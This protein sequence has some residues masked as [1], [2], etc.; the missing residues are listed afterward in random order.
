MTAKSP[1]SGEGTMRRFGTGVSG[2]AGALCMAGLLAA[3][4]SGSSSPQASTVTPKGDTV[5][6]VA[7]GV[8]PKSGYLVYWDQNEEVDFLSMPSGLQGQ[9]LPAWDLNGQVCVLPDGRFVG[10]YDPTLPGQRNLGSAKP[11]KQPPDGEELDEPNGSFSGQ[12]LYVPGRY[13]LA[14]ETIGSD[15]P[16]TPDGVFN[17]NQTY[18]GC[19]VMK[20]GNILG[21]DIA[22]AQGDYPPPSSG[23]LVEWFAPNYTT[24]C[25]VYGPTSGG[26]GPHHT[27]GTGGLA[28]PGM[29]NLADNGDVL[30]PN[31][32]TSS[33]LR[34]AQSSLPTSAAQCPGGVYPRA[35]VHVSA[36]V[37]DVSFPAGVAKDPTCDCFAV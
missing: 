33:V 23:R 35:S 19:A 10:G 7:G 2:L 15:S 36:F 26:T 8:L 32:G 21:N 30:V 25:I 5:P 31:V 1:S 3:C 27:D 12:T 18:T 16:P 34:F 22:D 4:S 20:N 29:M 11:Y 17:N 14:G 9:L 37:S 13:K 6:L 24:Y 28:Q